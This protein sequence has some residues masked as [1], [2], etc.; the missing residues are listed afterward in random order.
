MSTINLWA[1]RVIHILRWYEFK[2]F[3]PSPHSG[4]VSSKAY[5]VLLICE[6]EG[7]GSFLAFQLSL[8][9]ALSRSLLYIIFHTLIKR[10]EKHSFSIILLMHFCYSWSLFCFLLIT[11]GV[12]SRLQRNSSFAFRNLLFG[13]PTISEKNVN[14]K[15][16]Y[17]AGEI[18]VRAMRYLLWNP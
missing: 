16:I 8:W 14:S 10:S 18:N 3:G 7:W 4:Q 9:M 12:Q 15:I 13:I 17:R 5:F 6:K 2:I 11:E 1:L